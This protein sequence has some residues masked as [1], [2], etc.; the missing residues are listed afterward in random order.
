MRRWHCSLVLFRHW[1]SIKILFYVRTFITLDVLNVNGSAVFMWEAEHRRREIHSVPSR[2]VF[3]FHDVVDLV[4]PIVTEVQHARLLLWCFSI[5][6][7]NLKSIHHPWRNPRLFKQKKEPHLIAVCDDLSLMWNS[8]LV[9]IVRVIWL[10]KKREYSQMLLRGCHTK[11][12]SK[13]C[14][15]NIS[16]IA[17]K[18]SNTFWYVCNDHHIFH[19]HFCSGSIVSYF[20]NYLHTMF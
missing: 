7:P 10:E 19:I 3:Y 16:I 14:L 12:L 17:N 9:S 20:Q 15:W 2:N 4:G 6:R 1:H 5:S 11:R 8:R 18:Y 13:R